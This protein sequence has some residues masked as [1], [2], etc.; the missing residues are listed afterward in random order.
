MVGTENKGSL[1]KGFRIMKSKTFITLLML[2]TFFTLAVQAQPG[3]KWPDD[4][5]IAEKAKEKNALYSDA[6]KSKMYRQAANNLSWLLVKAPDL[7]S[8]IY[9]NGSKIYDELADAEKDAA[10]K[11]VYQDS[12][13]LLYDLRIK[14]FN[15]KASV[16]NR[17]AFAAYKYHKS[18]PSKYKELYELFKESVELNGN[19]TWDNNVLAYFDV[20][21]RYQKES[22]VF[23]NEE[24]LDLFAQVEGI[25]LYKRENNKTDPEKA[26]IIL[27]Q[28]N[29]M[30][31]EMIDVDCD[32]IS[33]TLGPKFMEN[34]DL[35]QAKTILRLSIAGKCLDAGSV[36]VDAAKYIF[37]NEKPEFTLAKLIAGRCYETGDYECAEKYY[38]EAANLTDDNKLES[39]A[40]LSLANIQ[41]KRGRKSSARD[42]A[43]KA[44]S[45]NP[46]NTSAASFIGA[47][48][49]N[50]YNDCKEEK[51]P[52]YDRAVF[53]AAYNWYAK[54][55]D[56]SGMAKAKEQFPSM[57]DIFTWN[58]QI[59]QQVQ[60]GCWVGETV[61]IQK[62]D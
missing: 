26:N 2:L 58:Y 3:W 6:L 1:T 47:L 54:A 42:Y 27:D 13:L 44:I 8:S 41:L 25:M 62:R 20:V 19:K 7:N 45:I 15:K 40:Y 28:I 18:E 61:K 48:Y 33:N 14:Y 31:V 12:S 38:T 24:V 49:M 57:E 43:K 10:K 46:Q 60:I 39:E 11:K 34:P 37:E 36:A 17:K 59:D 35:K 52:V 32:F 16:L 55:G 23:S 56:N 22:S 51:D 30:L 50:S 5:A 21:R 53:I 4:E 29:N 9:I